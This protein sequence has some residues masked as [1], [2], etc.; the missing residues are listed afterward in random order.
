MHIPEQMA[1][2]ALVLSN[3]GQRIYEI[4]KSLWQLIVL[5][6]VHEGN[7][8]YSKTLAVSVVAAHR[9]GTSERAT[10][11]SVLV[12]NGCVPSKKALRSKVNKFDRGAI[13][14]DEEWIVKRGRKKH[15]GRVRY[16]D[17]NGK[18]LPTAGFG[19]RLL[20]ALQPVNADDLGRPIIKK[21]FYAP[22]R[23]ID[24]YE[25][26]ADFVYFPPKQFA[27]PTNLGAADKTETYAKLVNYIYDASEK[28]G[29]PVV[30]SGSSHPG[31]KR[32]V[33]KHWKKHNCKY[34]FILKWDRFGY[35]I[36]LYGR[37]KDKISNVNEIF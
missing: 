18:M 28:C 27:T 22:P 6:Q 7:H 21:E 15:H 1:N 36:H 4:S 16:L 29:T 37:R 13:V 10:A 24:L 9:K 32:F 11:F 2:G 3:Q 23:I 30:S 14:I 31:S 35:Y 17:I 25:C 20:M 12:D 26:A 19:G 5:P 34:R 33:C 8:L